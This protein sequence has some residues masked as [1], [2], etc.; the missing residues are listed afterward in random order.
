MWRINMRSIPATKEGPDAKDKKKSTSLPISCRR[1]Q[2]LF[3]TS[4]LAFV[5]PAEI[6]LSCPAWCQCV[7][8]PG[9]VHCRH[10]LSGMGCFEMHQ[11]CPASSKLARSWLHLNPFYLQVV[12][13][14]CNLQIAESIRVLAFRESTK[15]LNTREIFRHFLVTHLDNSSNLRSMSCGLRGGVA[16]LTGADGCST[17]CSPCVSLPSAGGAMYS[18]CEWLEGL[19]T[20]S[21]ILLVDLGT[22]LHEFCF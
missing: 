15:H 8:C 16:G 21:V 2:F 1:L 11:A 3:I 7:H 18:N 20:G 4:D 13:T 12:S 5:L 14:A 10:H 17:A 6:A 19:D 22:L 9:R